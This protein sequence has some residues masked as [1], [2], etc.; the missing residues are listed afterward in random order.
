MPFCVPSESVLKKRLLDTSIGFGAQLA[1]VDF[2]QLL[3]LSVQCGVAAVE[4]VAP[5]R[6][7]YPACSQM[8]E[9]GQAMRKFECA[10]FFQPTQRLTVDETYELL[11]FLSRERPEVD[12]GRFGF[13]QFLSV[14]A[15]PLFRAMPHGVLVE[16]RSR[17]Q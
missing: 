15:P 14:R 5:Q 1:D 7:I 12:R 8:N 11:A 17:K 4:G 9:N 10:D 6:I 13:A 3:D 2:E 16:V